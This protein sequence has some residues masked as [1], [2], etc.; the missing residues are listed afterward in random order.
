VSRVFFRIILGPEPTLDDFKSHK[1]LGKP[2]LRERMRREWESSASV[3]DDLE[4]AIA[5]ALKFPSLGSQIARLVVP[6]DGS[7]GFA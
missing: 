2:L 3:Y 7:V 4:H 1:L 6:D 5:Q